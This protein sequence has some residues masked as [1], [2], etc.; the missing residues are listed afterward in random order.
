LMFP[1]AGGESVLI[2]PLLFGGA[3]PGP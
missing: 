1:P 2:Q 3:V